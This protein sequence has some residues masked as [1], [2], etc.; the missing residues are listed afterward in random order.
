MFKC[1][2]R[3]WM[4]KTGYASRAV[5]QRA[6]GYY[7]ARR[8]GFQTAVR[9]AVVKEALVPPLLG[10][11]SQTLTLAL[12]GVKDAPALACKRGWRCTGAR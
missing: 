10:S 3:A 4:L 12:M 2:A 11:L 8:Y 5:Q 7:C 6:T 1:T 9:T